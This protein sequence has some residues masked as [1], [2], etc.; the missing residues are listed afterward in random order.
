LLL[1]LVFVLAEIEQLADGRVGVG[2]DFHQIEACFIGPLE[3]LVQ[4]DHTDHFAPAV[5]ETDL[6]GLNLVID[7]RP[8]LGRRG[9]HRKTCDLDFSSFSQPNLARPRHNRHRGCPRRTGRSIQAWG[10]AASDLILAMASSS[11]RVSCVSEP[12]RRSATVR[13]LASRRPAANNSGTLA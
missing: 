10:T 3:A 2:R 7:A 11:A 12:C 9:L 6:R 13:S 5:D 1:K 8:I 4:A